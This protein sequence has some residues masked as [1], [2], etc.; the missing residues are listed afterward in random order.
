M[1]VVARAGKT[2]LDA[3]KRATS[4]LQRGA[5]RIIGAIVNQQSGSAT[6]GYYFTDYTPDANSPKS[7]GGRPQLSEATSFSGGGSR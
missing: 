2:R 3:L 1:I 5:V 4:T 6:E 7:G